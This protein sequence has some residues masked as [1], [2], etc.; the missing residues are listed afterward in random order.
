MKKIFLIGLFALLAMQGCKKDETLIDGKRP[1][2][3]IKEGL[4]K[5]ASELTGSVNGWKGYIYTSNIGGGYSFYLNF[6]KSNRVTML[7]DLDIAAAETGME[8]SYQIKQVMVPTLIFD[9]YSYL[10]LLTDPNSDV[11]GGDEGAG[12]GS[13]FEFEIREQKGDTLKLVGKKRNTQF[14]LIKATAADKAFYT[15]DKYA[16]LIDDVA[17]Y[18]ASN[19]FLYIPDPKN[20]VNRVQVNVTPD[21]YTRMFTFTSLEAGVIKSTQVPFAFSTTGIIFSKPLEFGG[22]SFTSADWD[23]VSSKFMLNTSSGT[24]VEILSGTSA[25]I[26]LHEVMGTALISINMPGQLTF[27]GSGQTF[28]SAYTTFK[29]SVAAGFSTPTIVRDLNVSF[30]AVSKT[31][32]IS[33][34]VVQNTTSVFP[35]VYTY[36]YTK[37]QNGEYR[38]SG[39]V[40]TGGGATAVLSRM[41]TFILNRIEAQTFTLDYYND[42]ANQRVL[43]KFSSKETPD[44]SLTGTLR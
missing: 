11:L 1:E 2:E 4:E 41:R 29:N 19:P 7:S 17:N 14:T 20:N 38:F 42:Q 37:T 32:A 13:D 44:F 35:A 36:N 6:N 30:N 8:S 18:V 33:V 31:M 26:P 12:F 23:T 3:R 34:N 5:Y 22:L 21:I 16:L 10:H 25:A 39:L 9:T 27:P 24:K 15:S 43:G 28:V 40:S